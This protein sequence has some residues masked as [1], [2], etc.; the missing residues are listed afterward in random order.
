VESAGLAVMLD[1]TIRTPYLSANF[2]PT[3]SAWPATSF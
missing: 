1:G 3:S 2:T